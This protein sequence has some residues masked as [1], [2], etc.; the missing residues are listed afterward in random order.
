MR[1]ACQGERSNNQVEPEERDGQLERDAERRKRWNQKKKKEKKEARPMSLAKTKRARCM[2][3]VTR[4]AC[5]GERSPNQKMERHVRSKRTV[6]NVARAQ[7]TQCCGHF[8][9]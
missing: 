5:Q 9:G 6:P 2:R 3:T 7:Y 8:R 1:S 4:I